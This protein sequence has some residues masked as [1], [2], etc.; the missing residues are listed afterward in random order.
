M[1]LAYLAASGGG[2]ASSGGGPPTAPPARHAGGAARAGA[3]GGE[4]LVDDAARKYRGPF[5]RRGLEV[6]LEQIGRGQHIGV[7][8]HDPLVR[9]R[10]RAPVAREIRRR[11]LRR[12]EN[13]DAG[14]LGLLA[15]GAVVDDRD[16]VDPTELDRQQPLG[17]AA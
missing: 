15:A 3:G 5:A 16:A 9:A 12:P 4:R 14:D 10:A 1:S 6:T 8:E 13:R 2:G 11:S 7:E 17:E